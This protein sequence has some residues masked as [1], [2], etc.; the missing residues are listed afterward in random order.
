MTVGA[1]QRRFQDFRFAYTEI[2]QITDGRKALERVVATGDIY[3]TTQ[4]DGV[5]VLVDESWP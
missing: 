2:T 1:E 5:T 3:K 4:G